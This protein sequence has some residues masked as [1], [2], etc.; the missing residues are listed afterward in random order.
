MKAINML[1]STLLQGCFANGTVLTGLRWPITFLLGRGLKYSCKSILN[2]SHRCA[3][4]PLLNNIFESIFFSPLSF[5]LHYLGRDCLY[6]LRTRQP[7]GVRTPRRAIDRGLAADC[8][9]LAG[10]VLS[11]LNQIQAIFLYFSSHSQ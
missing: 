9:A 4:A 11:A 2:K 3:L 5:I 7:G 6:P 8:N 10:L 1:Q